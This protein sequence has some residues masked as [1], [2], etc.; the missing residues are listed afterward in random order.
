MTFSKMIT[1]ILENELILF[2]K[3][4]ILGRKKKSLSFNEIQTSSKEVELI[5]T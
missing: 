1:N 4:M 2:W 3:T 5:F